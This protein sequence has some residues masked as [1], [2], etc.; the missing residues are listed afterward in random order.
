[1]VSPGV[2]PRPSLNGRSFT[3]RYACVLK[4]SPGVNPR[5]SL[6]GNGSYVDPRSRSGVAGGEPPALIERL[7][8]RPINL[9]RNRVAG[10][11]PPALIERD[12]H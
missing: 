5:P 6:N 8:Q 12:R 9:H 3:G 7:K 4:V 2:N 1:M 11:E 10:G